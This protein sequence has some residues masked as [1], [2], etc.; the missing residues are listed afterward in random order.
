MS[1]QVQQV[2]IT[3]NGVKVQ[4]PPGITHFSEIVSSTGSH[5]KTNKIT[6]V[7][8]PPSPPATINGNDSYNIVGGEIF[9]STH[10]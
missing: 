10:G 7:T 8:G 9:T 2:T 5:P 6:I 4:V 1:V 3:V